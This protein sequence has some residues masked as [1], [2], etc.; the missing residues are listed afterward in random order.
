V[1]FSI[2][3]LTPIPILNLDRQQ[4]KQAMI[5]LVDNAVAAVRQE[6]TVTIGLRHDPETGRVEITVADDGRGIT[7]KDRTRLFEP[8]FST[9]KSGMGLGL[10][11]VHT[12]IS[13]HGGSIRAEHNQPRG[14][15]FIIEL[16]V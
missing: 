3:T 11:I 14:A 15:K 16:P 13:D 1:Q 8:D 5:N 7:L 10:T 2:E 4:I 9:K 6:G 12:I